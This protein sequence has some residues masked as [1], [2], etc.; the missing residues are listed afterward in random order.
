MNETFTLEHLLRIGIK[1]ID[2]NIYAVSTEDSNGYPVDP[3]ELVSYLFFN[4]ERTFFGLLAEIKEDELHLRADQLLLSFPESHPYVK[5]EGQ[6]EDDEQTLQS[7]REAADAW[8][9]PKIWNYVET[10]E[11][12]IHFNTDEIA[13]SEESVQIIQSAVYGRL[14]DSALGPDQLPAL[15]P[16]LRKYGWPGESVSTIPVR[17]AFRLTE[18]EEDSDSAEWLLETVVVGERERHW[19]PAVRKRNLPVTEALPER[20]AAYADEIAERQ[21][22]MISLLRSIEIESDGSFLSV[23]IHDSEVRLFIQ[24]D[25][26]LLQ[27]FNYTIILPAW[28][29][30]ITESKMRIRTS[31]SVQ[32]YNSATN[33]DEVLNFDWNFSLGG[34]E[35]GRDAF[36]KLVEEN[37]EYIRSGD[38][39]F[40]IDPLWLKKIKDIMDRADSG[41]WTVK[42]LLFQDI[43]EEIVPI[44]S[45][46]DEDDPLFE[47][48]MQKSLKSYMEV[49]AD[50]K[51]LPSAGIPKQL[52]AELRPYQEEGYDWLIFMRDNQFGAVLADDMGL[53]KTIQLIAYLLNVHARPETEKPSLIICPTS[54]LGNWQKEIERFAP[55]LSVHTHYG[56]SR[57]KDEEFTGLIAHLRPDVIL[58]TYGTASQDGE[59]LAETEF[60]SITLDEAQNI[61]NMQTRQSRMIRK[62]RGQHHIALTGTPIENRL[63]ELW[64]IFDFVHKGY[65]G[66]F[67]AFTDNFIVPIERDDSERDKQKLR[68][69]IRPFLLRRT[70]N[71]PDL[72]LN[73]PKKLEQNEYVP[74]TTEQAALYESFLDE[75]KYKLQTLT[76]FERKGLIL[77][78]LSRLKQLCNHPVLFLK[79]PHGPAEQLIARSDKLSG[80]VSMAGN[81]ADNGEQCIIFTQ[82]IGMGKLIQHCLSEMHNIDVPFLT[83]SMPKGQRDNLVDAFQ[84]GEFPVFI[85]SLRAGGTGL[86]LT[87][88]NHVLHAD[89]WWNPAVE[90]QA[91]DRAYRIG[92]TKFVHVHKF[93]TIGTIEE[94]IDKMLTEKAALSADLIQSSQWLTE[95]SDRELDDL[96]SFG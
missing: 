72:L 29:K 60:T 45:D 4:D 27:S 25:L 17:V 10:N 44:E 21:S 36:Q 68:A 73:L 63:S 94:K 61:K 82:Y 35:I 6:T 81:I 16:H 62:L 80:I 19:T 53:G 91:T 57:E 39:W 84:N 47:F 31:A 70:K 65:F 87:A 88:A 1:P 55:T 95:L 23:P 54:V 93:V 2:G 30:S 32:S 5:F 48:S 7:I 83:G 52:N 11:T 40:H 78:M 15:L 46:E 51:G 85:L 50:K 28:L 79:E 90:N 66:N 58:T 69:K 76:G 33:L 24:E 75:T 42:D 37:R 86:N 9:N 3:E 41:E 38:E 13:L 20:W 43:P 96:L 49:L 26:P 67:R 92:Q 14:A 56:P 71:D 77:T 74:L 34:Q 8:R 22:E 18:P 12:G 59:M 89:R 64:A